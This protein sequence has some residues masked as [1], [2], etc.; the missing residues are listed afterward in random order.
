MPVNQFCYTSTK[1]RDLT[2]S[3]HIF[4]INSYCFPEA[5][6]KNMS[7]L[8]LG[9]YLKYVQFSFTQLYFQNALF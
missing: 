9:Q 1:K 7:E 4:I 6:N 3:H 8:H 5:R 2:P